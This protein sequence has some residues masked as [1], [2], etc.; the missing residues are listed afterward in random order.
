MARCPDLAKRRR[1]GEAGAGRI[2]LWSLRRCVSSVVLTVIYLVPLVADRLAPF[3]PF[4]MERRLGEAV[5]MQ[6]RRALRLRTVHD[7]TGDGGACPAL[8]RADRRRRPAACR[9]TI[10]VLPSEMVNAVAL[11]GGHVYVFAGLLKAADNPDELAGVIASRARP[12]RG[13]RRIAKTAGDGRKLVPARPALRRHH[14][15]RR[16]HLRR[17]DAGRQPLLAR[18][19]SDGRRFSAQS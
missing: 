7:R 12:R 5:D 6:V 8:D 11:P 9:S 18:G 14:R 19:R 10:A 4:A 1:G 13:A 15:R 2:V 3:I 17:A 16:N